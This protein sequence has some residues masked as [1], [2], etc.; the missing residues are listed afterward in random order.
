MG[1]K[2]DKEMGLLSMPLSH[3]TQ[4]RTIPVIILSGFLGTGKTTLLKQWLQWSTEAQLVPAVIM[5][6]VGEVNLDGQQLPPEVAMKEMLGGCICCSFR[7]DFSMKLYELVQEENPD[8]IYVECTG[9]AE[10]MELV[11]SIT[12]VSLYSQIVLTNIVTVVDVKHLGDLL[13]D[14]SGLQKANRKM[15]RLLEEQIRAAHMILLN[16][17]DLAT[18]DQIELVQQQVR[19]WNEHAKLVIT[20]HAV[21]G[22]EMWLQ[23]C[24]NAE[25]SRLFVKDDLQSDNQIDYASVSHEHSEQPMEHTKHEAHHH[26]HAHDFVTAWTYSLTQPMDSERFEQWLSS[27]PANVYR[28]KGIV[29]FTDTTKRYMFQFAYRTSDFIPVAPQGEVKDVLV[30]IGE[31]LDTNLL[32]Q[33]LIE[34]VFQL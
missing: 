17:S 2:H 24:I 23:S 12:E 33:T 5:N 3:R 18:A 26:A 31:H 22:R 34:T 6:E 27:L 28:A 29:S 32:E 21:M 19:K 30:V 16:K 7:G 15:V 14:E 1:S 9:I 4:N 20:D 13:A 8:V 11:E 10:P 25:G